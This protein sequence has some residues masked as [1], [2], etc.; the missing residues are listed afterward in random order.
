[1]TSLNFWIGGKQAVKAAA[2]NPS[3]KIIEIYATSENFDFI[4]E[5]QNKVK[6]KIKVTTKDNKSI[7]KVFKTD[8]VHQGVA[9][10]V[11]KNKNLELD[12][13][14][15][16]QDKSKDSTVVILDDLTDQR[17][18]G[19]IIRSCVA[20]YVDAIFIL[21]K[22]Y[23]F[24]NENMNKTASGGVEHIDIIPV[25]NVCNLIEKLK[26]NNFWVTGLDLESHKDICK[27][28]WDSKTAIVLGSEGLGMRKLVKEHCDELLKINTNPKIG[29]LN[30]SNALA[31]T[32]ML[33][34][35]QKQ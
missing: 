21:K 31:A 24:N 1:M 5:I 17:N 8:I 25:N 28:K 30:V 29:S 15:K 12:D 9:A 11:E 23:S 3:R 34:S 6:K 4:N 20:F 26:K 16:L 7:N 33:R 22:N 32:L 18:I 14:L 10:F 13:F 2:L 35:L 19:S 27:Y